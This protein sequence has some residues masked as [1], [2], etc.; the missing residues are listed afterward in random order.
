MSD[1]RWI[2]K[3][4]GVCPIFVLFK[5]PRMALQ[6]K[7]DTV[8]FYSDSSFRPRKLCFHLS[9]VLA[10]DG[11]QLN[12]FLLLMFSQRKMPCSRPHLHTP[13]RDTTFNDRSVL[14]T[15][16]WLLC[17]NSE[18]WQIRFSKVL[19]SMVS[20]FNFSCYPIL[21]LLLLSAFFPQTML[22]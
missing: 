20:Q 21:L 19:V 4:N 14:T 17:F 2:H 11:L 5:E 9:G 10:V 8:V 12:L 7:G 13:Q 16:S 1:Y 22:Q 3:G 15:K 18:K 6:A